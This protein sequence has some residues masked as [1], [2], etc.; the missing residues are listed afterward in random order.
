MISRLVRYTCDRPTC[1]ETIEVEAADGIPEGFY[2]V[3]I[4]KRH[5]EVIREQIFCSPSC[6]LACAEESVAMLRDRRDNLDV[7]EADRPCWFQVVVRP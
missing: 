1:T 6:L 4:G 7:A 3:K 2:Q 5:G